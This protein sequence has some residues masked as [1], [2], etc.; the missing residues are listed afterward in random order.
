MKGFMKVC[1]EPGCPTL[2]EVGYCE[3][4]TRRGLHGSRRDRL[5]RVVLAQQGGVC[6]ICGRVPARPVLDHVVPLKDGGTDDG[7]NLQVLCANPCH[8]DKTVE[9]RDG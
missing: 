3:Q 8:R 1:G 4:H 9:E 2:V 7:E 6:A 5:R